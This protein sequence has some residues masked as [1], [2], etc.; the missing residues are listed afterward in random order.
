M[1]T[2]K[3]PVETTDQSKLDIDTVANLVVVEQL[4]LR[5]LLLRPS[6]SALGKQ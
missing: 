5:V 6:S 1:D 2:E 4:C 3:K